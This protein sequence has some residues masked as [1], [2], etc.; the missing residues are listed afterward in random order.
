MESI[1][2]SLQRGLKGRRASG[3]PGYG[4]QIVRC[5]FGLQFTVESLKEHRGFYS[6]MLSDF[7]A[8]SSDSSLVFVND[9]SL[10]PPSSTAIDRTLHL[11]KLPDYT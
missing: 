2:P 7:K 11:M 1:Y 8:Q 5:V 9:Q 4:S 3:C 10:V 6:K